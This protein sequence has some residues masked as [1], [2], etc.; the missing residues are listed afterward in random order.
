[1]E[2]IVKEE[3]QPLSGFVESKK[4]FVVWPK[5]ITQLYCYRHST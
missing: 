4:C 2:E 5:Q 1:M 3:L